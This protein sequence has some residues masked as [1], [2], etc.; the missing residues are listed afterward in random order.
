MPY[1]AP[2]NPNH[3]LDGVI[4]HLGIKNDAALSRLLSLAPPVISK[5]RH[6]HLPVSPGVLLKL[7][8]ASGLSIETLRALLY[9]QPSSDTDA[10]A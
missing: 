7:Y 2:Q 3:L 4:L 1:K 10:N 9:H 6:Q 8:D 5:I